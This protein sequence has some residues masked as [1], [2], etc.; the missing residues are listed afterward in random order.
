VPNLQ[1]FSLQKATDECRLSKWKS[2]LLT[3]SL[4]TH[5]R[6]VWVGGNSCW[7]FVLR[8]VRVLCVRYSSLRRADYTSRGALP[9]MTSRQWGRPDFA[10]DALQYI[11]GTFVQAPSL[12]FLFHFESCSSSVGIVTRLRPGRVKFILGRSRDFYFRQSFHTGSEA[13]PTFC[14]MGSGF[15]FHGSK[16]T[17]A[18]S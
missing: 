6:T 15:A 7:K 10:L 5:K 2:C 18:W 11:R 16:A 9:I 13:R 3:G 14:G 4:E 17:V 8:V 1:Y 12:Y